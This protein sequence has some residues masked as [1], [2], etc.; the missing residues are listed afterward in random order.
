MRHAPYPKWFGRDPHP[1]PHALARTISDT[2]LCIMWRAG[3]CGVAEQWICV[4]LRGLP[5]RS[6][7]ATH[8]AALSEVRLFSRWKIGFAPDSICVAISESARSF[9]PQSRHR[10]NLCR[11]PS[12]KPG[13][14][15]CHDQEE[16][17]GTAQRE[18][19]SRSHTVKMPAQQSHNRQG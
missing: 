15:Q 3:L 16:N 9:A 8:K 7:I 6:W 17:G 13:R 18:W 14:D 12:G 10:I 5:P 1:S 4:G 2:P 11:T 19:I